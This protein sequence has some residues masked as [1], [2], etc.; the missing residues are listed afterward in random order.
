MTERITVDFNTMNTDPEDRVYLPTSING[1]LR[2]IVRPGLRLVLYE[3]FDFEV[4]AVVEYEPAHEAWY[5][6]PDW[7]TR[8]DLESDALHRYWDVGHRIERWREQYGDNT[9]H[10]AM[11]RREAATVWTQLT[12]DERAYLQEDVPRYAAYGQARDD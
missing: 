9:A 6:R 7:S 1:R 10:E 4:E 5:G 8:R 12:D 11:L 3:P 2:E